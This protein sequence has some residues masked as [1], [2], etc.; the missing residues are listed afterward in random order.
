VGGARGARGG[1]DKCAVEQRLYG[2]MF[3]CYDSIYRRKGK[4]K[5]LK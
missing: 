3:L 1:E 2:V 5:K 4:R